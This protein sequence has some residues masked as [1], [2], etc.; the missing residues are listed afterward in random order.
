MQLVIFSRLQ[1]RIRPQVQLTAEIGAPLY[2]SC[3][4]E[5]DL[6]PT[7]MWMK[8]GKPSLPVDSSIIQNNTLFDFQCQE[9]TRGILRL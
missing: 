2:L 8:D 3:V 6:K 1:F 7:L 9:I 4:A 5:S